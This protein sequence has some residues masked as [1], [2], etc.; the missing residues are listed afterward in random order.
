VTLQ[1]TSPGPVLPMT[2]GCTEPGCSATTEICLEPFQ[3][4]NIRCLDIDLDWSGNE[5]L[6]IFVNG[7]DGGRCTPGSDTQET[8][9]LCGSFT[10][11]ETGCITATVDASEFVDFSP[12]VDESGESYFVFCKIEDRE[13]DEGSTPT[14]TT[15]QPTL[16]P[17]MPTEPPAKSPTPLCMDLT[18]E[19]GAPWHDQ[20]NDGFTCEWYERDYHFC[21]RDGDKWGTP[22]TANEACCFCG[23][24]QRDFGDDA[25]SSPSKTPTISPVKIPPTN[26]PSLPTLKPTASPLCVDSSQVQS[27]Y[28]IVFPGTGITCDDAV[29][30]ANFNNNG[31]CDTDLQQICPK[32]CGICSDSPTSRPTPRVTTSAPTVHSC[33]DG[34]CTPAKMSRCPQDCADE[35]Q[36]DACRCAAVFGVCGETCLLAASAFL[37]DETCMGYTEASVCGTVLSDSEYFW[38]QCDLECDASEFSPSASPVSTTTDPTPSTTTAEPTNMPS[39]PIMCGDQICSL[40]ESRSCPLDCPNEV[41]NDLCNCAL[42]HD[43]C[44]KTCL[45]FSTID[46]GDDCTYFNRYP[47]CGGLIPDTQPLDILCASRGLTCAPTRAP[48]VSTTTTISTTIP[49]PTTEAPCTL[50]DLDIFDNCRDTCAECGSPY[51]CNSDGFCDC[52]SNIVPVGIG[53]D[54]STMCSTCGGG[55]TCCGGT[56][57]MCIILSKI[58]FHIR[59]YLCIQRNLAYHVKR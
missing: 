49:Q 28:G 31:R 13:S 35:I 34:V 23:G 6:D 30:I 22:L 57:V 10:A 58:T 17:V 52:P 44:G 18:F 37:D 27:M 41:Y 39:V 54:C 46:D 21:I 9:F 53:G 7:E 14:T 16:N 43:M 56:C 38:Q 50:P 32:A 33:G 25:S 3:S 2:W 11:P 40:G 48:T 19:N 55:L 45:D 47:V 51:V 8:F 15:A 20:L 36:R 59:F 5:F 4:F 42:R 12:Y 1:T 26:A 29:R 24:G